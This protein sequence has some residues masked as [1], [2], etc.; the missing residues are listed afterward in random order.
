MANVTIYDV[1]G[2]FVTQKTVRQDIETIP[3]EKKGCYIVFVDETQG[4]EVIVW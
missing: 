2:R 4:F 1:Q 3:L